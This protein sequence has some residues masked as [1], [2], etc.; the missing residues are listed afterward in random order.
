MSYATARAQLVAIMAAVVPTDDRV[1]SA[2]R[3]FVHI[4]EGRSGLACPSRS[5]WLSAL[6]DGDGGVTGPFTPELPGQPRMTF[7]L[8]LT[9]SY[10][11]YERRSVMDEVLGADLIAY[12]AALLTPSN[13]NRPTSGI[14]NITGAGPLFL[15]TRRVVVGEHTEQ[16]ST[17]SLWFN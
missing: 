1:F 8:T 15:P 3:R 14:H 13:W 5:F 7:P 6:E 2:N 16:R 4:P 10:R 9:V 17:L 11:T 12:S